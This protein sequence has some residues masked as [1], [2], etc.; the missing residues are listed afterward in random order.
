MTEKERINS[1]FLQDMYAHFYI[2][3]F[4]TPNSK[5]RSYHSI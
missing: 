3:V 4:H 1:P 2:Y 5:F